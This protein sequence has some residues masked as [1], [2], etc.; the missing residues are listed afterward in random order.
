MTVTA[1]PYPPERYR[2]RGENYVTGSRGVLNNHARRP[3]ESFDV[4]PRLWP[5]VPTNGVKYLYVSKR[6]CFPAKGPRERGNSDSPLH[7]PKAY[8]GTG[9]G[10]NFTFANA[11]VYTYTHVQ[12]R[13]RP[14]TRPPVKLINAS[15]FRRFPAV[16][17]CPRTH[18]P[19]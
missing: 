12:V 14:P 9:G 11:L 15:V 3:P 6:Q 7:R 17:T 19:T 13:S 2:R 8:K 16:S 18:V 1:S 5:R 4:R 10:D